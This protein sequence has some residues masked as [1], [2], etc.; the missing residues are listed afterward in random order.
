[1]PEAI[2]LKE[3]GLISETRSMLTYAVVCVSEHQE[4]QDKGIL[5]PLWLPGNREGMTGR[6][7]PGK[8]RASK[9]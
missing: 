3:Q 8:K 7:V 2:S 4:A 6:K 9:E 5:L 1:M